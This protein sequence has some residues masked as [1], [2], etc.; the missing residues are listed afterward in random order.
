MHLMCCWTVW[1]CNSRE[2]LLLR[3]LPSI[4]SAKWISKL[5]HLNLGLLNVNLWANTASPV[6][7]K[8]SV[9]ASWTCYTTLLVSLAYPGSFMSHTEWMKSC[10]LLFETLLAYPWWDCVG[11]TQ[12]LYFQVPIYKNWLLQEYNMMKKYF[13]FKMFSVCIAWYSVY[14]Y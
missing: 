1:K 12:C 11:S 13:L 9:C 10:S 2:H 7:W 8:H 6:S 3:F 5:I 4:F 14:E